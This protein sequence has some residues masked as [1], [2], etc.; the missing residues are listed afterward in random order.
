MPS[1]PL[2]CKVHKWKTD[3][4]QYLKDYLKDENSWVKAG[5]CVPMVS[6]A[7]AAARGLEALKECFALR[8]RNGLVILA[9]LVLSFLATSRFRMSVKLTIITVRKRF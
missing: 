6:V 4:W 9:D 1:L 8:P 7:T 5:A 3:K 2:G